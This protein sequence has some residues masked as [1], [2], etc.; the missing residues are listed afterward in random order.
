MWIG[1]SQ[2]DVFSS[3]LVFQP[4]KFHQGAPITISTLKYQVIARKQSN[5]NSEEKWT[6]KNN[7]DEKLL[8]IDELATTSKITDHHASRIRGPQPSNL[9]HEGCSFLCISLCTAAGGQPDVLFEPDKP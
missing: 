4:P 8:W 3:L 1:Q 2:Q 6:G 5:Q 7:L 9:N